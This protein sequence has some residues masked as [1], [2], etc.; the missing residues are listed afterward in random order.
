MAPEHTLAA[1]H[2]R[3]GP[4]PG[5]RQALAVWTAGRAARVFLWCL[6]GMVSITSYRNADY[7]YSMWKGGDASTW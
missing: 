2:P 7:S 3:E 6:L 5:A 1:R 4:L